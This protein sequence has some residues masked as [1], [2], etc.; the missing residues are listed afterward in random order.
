MPVNRNQFKPADKKYFTQLDAYTLPA[1]DQVPDPIF[2]WVQPGEMAVKAERYKD[3]IANCREVLAKALDMKKDWDQLVFENMHRLTGCSYHYLLTGEE[4]AL[5]W[6]LPSIKSFETCKRPHFTFSTC[7]GVM[8]LDLR[9]AEVVYSLACLK[10]AFKGKLDKKTVARIDSILIDRLLVPGLHA[11]RTKQYPWM[12][13]TANWRVILCGMFGLGAMTMPH[14]LKDWREFVEFGLEGNLVS[15]ATGD[16]SGGWNEG[17]GYWDYG[18]QY[19]SRFAQSLDVFTQGK[20]DLFSHPFLKKTGHFWLY[21]HTKTNELWNWSDCSKPCTAS[22]NLAMLA[23]EYQNPGY[24]NMLVRDGIKNAGIIMYMDANLP[25]DKPAVGL[26]LTKNFGSTGALVMRTGFKDTDTFVGVK[27]G[28]MPDYNHHCQMDAGTVIIHAAGSELLAK[29]NHWSYP[30]EAPKDPKAPRPKRPGLYDEEL[31][32]WKRWDL[33]SVGALG[34]NIPVVEGL[35]PQPVLHVPPKMKLVHSDANHDV[36][37][38]D[39]SPYYKPAASKAIRL[40]A[41]IRPNIALIVDEIVAPKPIRAQVLYHYLDQATINR[42]D[43]TITNGKGQLNAFNLYPTEDD[44]MIVGSQDRRTFYEPP[45]GIVEVRN[46]FV[47]VENLWRKKRLIF[48]TA[49]HFDAAPLPPATFTLEGDPFKDATFKVKFAL[50]KAKGSLT[51][52]LGKKDIAY[53]P[54]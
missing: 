37:C 26:P 33:D 11:M 6:A 15:L 14:Q 41:F 42:H 1:P 9:S 51:V 12:L 50:E 48:V 52:N 18:L 5:E 16:P 38:V 31:K 20:V 44:N 8:D 39:S 46:R 45:P 49:L 53:K 7:M 35:Y 19:S 54:G 27:A 13:S 30:R 34:H 40:F 47:Y 4:T 23:R 32:R 22:L 3:A 17:P 2:G 10:S 25:S 36:V 24:Q 43:F 28:D 29:N 21:M